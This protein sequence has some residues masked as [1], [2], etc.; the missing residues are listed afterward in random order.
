MLF[1]LHGHITHQGVATKA[2]VPK[3]ERVSVSASQDLIEAFK[4]ELFSAYKTN[5]YKDLHPAW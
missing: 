3:I 1:K 2:R 5:G 4:S